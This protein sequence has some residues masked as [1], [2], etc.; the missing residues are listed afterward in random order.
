ML[1]VSSA[2]KGF[3]PPHMN[4]TQRDAIASPATGLTIYNT[5]TN[6]LESFNGVKHG[7]LLPIAELSILLE[8]VMEVVLYFIFMITGNMV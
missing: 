3:L 4:T 6:G 7:L 1:D 5:T 2:T 8:K